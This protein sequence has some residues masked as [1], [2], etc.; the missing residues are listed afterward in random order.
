MISITD[1]HNCCG[2][3]ACS[4][5][6]PKHCITMQ[7]DNEGFLYPLVDASTCIDCGLCEKVCLMVNR[8]EAVSPK[9]VCAAINC[10][11]EIRANSSSGGIFTMLAERIL[12]Q[13][14]VVFG[15]CFD[16][17][18]KVVHGY[19]GDE[20]TYEQKLQALAKFRGAKYSQSIIGDTYLQAREFLKEGRIVLFS[21][22]GC[23]IAGLKL[24]LRKDY[25]NLLTIEIACHGVPSPM[26][27]RDY[28]QKVS[29][30][31]PL[32]K[33]VFRDKRNG[34]NGYGLLL[35]GTDGQEL[36]Y[37]RTTANDFMQ[38]F[39]NDL[40]VRPSCTNCPAKSGAS[41][42]DVL[43][44]DFWGIEGMHP[45]MY[46]NKGCSLVIAFTEK[47]KTVFDSLDCKYVET[48]FEEAYRYNPCIVQSS[49]ESRYA[50]IFWLNYKKYGIDAIPKT[51]KLLKQ[52]R[53][54][55]ALRLLLFKLGL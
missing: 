22:T 12:E 52:S 30:G 35:V 34:W 24:F 55:R 53:I 26:V 37:E 32:S 45:E 48:T 2:C 5:I 4:S 41:G 9:F 7:A 54:K 38:C 29:N 39:L 46:D 11:D 43:I 36:M 42:A 21:G 14:G 49:H 31:S 3:S 17:K 50:P 1:K 27:W 47:G 13:G 28:V 40:C 18:W 10:S 19:V 23:Q 33:I 16:K 44:G 51:L 6:C 15:A 25:D 20:K 8:Q